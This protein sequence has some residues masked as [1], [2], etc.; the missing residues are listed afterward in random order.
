MEL[1]TEGQGNRSRRRQA[2]RAAVRLLAGLVR[3]V[4]SADP[5]AID[6]AVVQLGR[7][8]R[9]LAPL[10][11]AAGTVGLMLGGVKLLIVN[12]RLS[13]LELVPAACIWLT[14]WD[15]KQHFLYGTPF[16]QLNGLVL[17][18]LWL[19][20]VLFTILSLACNTVFAFAID[21]PP[22]PRI[23]PAARQARGVTGGILGWGMVLGVL[24]ACAV[25][26]VPRVVGLWMYGMILSGV[27][28]I[29]MTAFVAVPARLIGLRRGHRTLK[30]KIGGYAVGGV[31]S[32]VAVAPGYIVSRLG[33]ILLGLAG[34]RIVGFVLL[35]TGTALFAGG[36]SAA[37]AVK[38]GSKLAESPTGTLADPP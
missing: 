6:A 32:A 26:I 2:R 3:A 36:L 22:P 24:L 7:S 16:E 12:W 30:Q 13:L 17:A 14:T 31:L 5:E 27:L 33:L 4:S 19:V 18:I 8:R 29:M 37:R 28:A 38:L 20:V 10:G 21:G 23:T 35:T 34:W 9:Y 15:L 11:W 25:V 1:T